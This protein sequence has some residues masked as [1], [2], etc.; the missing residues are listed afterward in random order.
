MDKRL[1]EIEGETVTLSEEEIRNYCFL[2]ECFFSGG[3]KNFCGLYL[4]EDGK[5]IDPGDVDREFPED[6]YDEEGFL[7]SS[8]RQFFTLDCSKAIEH[9]GKLY[10]L[11]HLKEI[12]NS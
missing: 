7:I 1:F 10:L 2:G 3:G 9:G 4:R 8:S 11:D 6:M 5:L 12:K